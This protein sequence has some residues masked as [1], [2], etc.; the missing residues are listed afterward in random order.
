MKRSNDWWKSDCANWDISKQGD[1]LGDP[2]P[3]NEMN[4]SRRTFPNET[5]ANT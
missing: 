2:S 5:H 3:A 4:P 1:L